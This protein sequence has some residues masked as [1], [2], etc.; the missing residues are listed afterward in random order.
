[1]QEILLSNFNI[2]ILL[3]EPLVDTK[4][5]TVAIFALLQLFFLFLCFI[6]ANDIW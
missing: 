3:S 6:L 4:A 2:A 5:W 1:M